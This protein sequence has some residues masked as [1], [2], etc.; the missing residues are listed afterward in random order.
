MLLLV[1]LKATD[2]ASKTRLYDLFELVQTPVNII[3]IGEM[4]VLNK[5]HKAFYLLFKANIMYTS[6]LDKINLF[7]YL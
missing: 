1:S 7:H 5:E 2:L 4:C 3:I 6:L